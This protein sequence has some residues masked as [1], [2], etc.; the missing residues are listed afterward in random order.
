M[1]YSDRVRNSL[2]MQSDSD[3]C[4]AIRWLLHAHPTAPKELSLTY[5]INELY[6]Q[7]LGRRLFIDYM[8]TLESVLYVKIPDRDCVLMIIALADLQKPFTK[9]FRRTFT[10]VAPM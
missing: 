1:T 7:Y 2:C 4:R 9:A 3:R 6:E 10:Y 8:R 5:I